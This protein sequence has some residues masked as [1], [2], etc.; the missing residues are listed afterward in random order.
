MCPKH[1]PILI[2]LPVI[3][4][5]IFHVAGADAVILAVKK[6]ASSSYINRFLQP[7]SIIPD[8]TNPQALNR[9]SYVTNRPLL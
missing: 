1:C 3:S 9:Y 2:S 5:G 6:T 8:Y 7:D 4:G